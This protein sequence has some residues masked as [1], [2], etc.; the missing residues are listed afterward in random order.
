MLTSFRKFVILPLK[1]CE[2]YHEDISIDPQTYLCI[3]HLVMCLSYVKLTYETRGT[4]FGPS[5]VFDLLMTSRPIRIEDGR[6][7]RGRCEGKRERSAEIG[8]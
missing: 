6:D 4:G 8:R 3:F 2:N 5:F 7:V 1:R